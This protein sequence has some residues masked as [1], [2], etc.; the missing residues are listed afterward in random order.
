MDETHAVVLG[1]QS[2]GLQTREFEAAYGGIDSAGEEN[3]LTRSS[4]FKGDGD[5]IVD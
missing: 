2:L 4:P 3:V 1:R 5:R